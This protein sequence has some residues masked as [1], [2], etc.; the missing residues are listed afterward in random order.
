MKIQW[1]GD[2][3]TAISR[4]P[5]FVRKRVR[6][7]VEEE[8]IDSGAS[9]VTIAHVR[10]SQRKFL[11]NMEREVRGY[12]IATCFSA[13]GCPNQAAGDNDLVE[14][15][16]ELVSGKNLKTFL[17]ERVKGPLKMHHEFRITI[18][19]CPNACS[20]PQIVDIGI[21]GAQTP[22]VTDEPCSMCGACVE[23]C[24]DSAIELDNGSPVI[25]DAA[26]LKCGLCIRECPTGTLKTAKQGYRVLVGGKLGRHPQLGKELPGIHTS[27]EV[28]EIVDRCIRYFMDNNIKGE[29]FG[30][31]LK[32][33]GWESMS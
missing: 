13:G 3:E 15:L 8:A 25:D 17:K 16:E 30:V 33:T 31:I 9:K 5:F 4:V 21:I 27:A 6:K 12:G 28:L 20:R 11:K 18:S 1:T 24:P 2:A 29:R 26:C 14:K 23:I 19:D 32:R 22:G 10:A 7:R